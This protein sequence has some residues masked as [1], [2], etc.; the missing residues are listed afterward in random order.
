MIVVAATEVVEVEENSADFV[1]VFIEYS[2]S[3]L[4]GSKIKWVVNNLETVKHQWYH[5]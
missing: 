2:S 1:V 4:P 5:L 3:L